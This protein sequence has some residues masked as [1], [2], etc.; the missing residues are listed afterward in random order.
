[1]SDVNLSLIELLHDVH[2]IIRDDV[3]GCAGKTAFAKEGIFK[4]LYEGQVLSHRGNYRNLYQ[5]QSQCTAH[6]GA[7]DGSPRREIS[8]NGEF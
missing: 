6:R 1:M 5:E 4:V 7:R 3:R 2:E 8:K